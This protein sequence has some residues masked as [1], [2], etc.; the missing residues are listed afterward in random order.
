MGVLAVWTAFP[1]DHPTLGKSVPW[2]W[3]IL[4]FIFIFSSRSTIYTHISCSR[5]KILQLCICGYH[6]PGTN[7]RTEMVET[8]STFQSSFLETM[9]G[10][11]GRLSC[12]ELAT[13]PSPPHSADGS[14]ATAISLGGFSAAGLWKAQLDGPLIGVPRERWQL[15]ALCSHFS[16]APCLSCY[17]RTAV[18]ARVVTHSAVVVLTARKFC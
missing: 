18:T 14:S 15:L 16:S 13:E 4:D 11:L 9:L 2:C 7:T 10:Y 6:V 17:H 12:L 5:I 1:T 8:P 3:G